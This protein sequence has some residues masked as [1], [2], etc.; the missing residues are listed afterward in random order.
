MMEVRRWAIEQVAREFGVPL[1]MVGLDD[2]LKDAQSQ[3][4]SDTLPPYCEDYSRMLD[5][6]ILV[7]V[8]NWTDGCF[9]F[10]LDE[11]HMGDDRLKSLVSATGRP[12]MLTNEGRAKLNLPP[13][14]GGD[15]LVTPLNVI[16]GENPQAS[17]DVVNPPD[18][19]GQPRGVG[20][21]QEPKALVKADES[22][23]FT[24]LAPSRKGDL[25]RQYRNIDLAQAAVERHYGRLE[26]S[27]R[28]KAGTADWSRWDREFA[29]DL[30]GLLGQIIEKE[31]TIYA[32]KLGGEFDPGRVVNY[33][34][35]MAEGA[36]E[37]ING[38]IRA[39]IVSLGLAA[40]LAKRGQHVESAGAGLGS[41]ATRWAREEAARQSP[42]TDSR[43]KV[44]IPDTERH[45][46]YGGDTVALGAPWPAGFAP[47]AA[48]GCKC[49]MAII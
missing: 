30:N 5:Q 8:Y 41:G 11:K 38:A 9:E 2:N 44:W 13:V 21:D 34:K 43:V 7:R 32:F 16:V 46:K 35:A 19:N 20:V 33:L 28:A 24:P 49:S 26:R 29:D 12:V 31:A 18:P 45:A 47:G 27:L 6:R 3:F 22:E 42:D 36:A 23:K 14:E 25:D 1:G 17:V 39:E 40:A 37:G 48:P 4:Y 15:E 10:N